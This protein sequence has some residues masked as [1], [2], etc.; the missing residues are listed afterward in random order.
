MRVPT[1]RSAEH[2]EALE[3]ERISGIDLTAPMRGQIP[4]RTETDEPFQRPTVSF[5]KPTIGDLL[6]EKKGQV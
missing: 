6:I 4:D 1:S 5:R 3:H 2:R